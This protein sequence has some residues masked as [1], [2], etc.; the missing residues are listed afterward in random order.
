MKERSMKIFIRSLLFFLIPVILLAQA[1]NIE[2]NLIL[3][4]S[5]ANIFYIGNI[6]PTG[7]GNVPDYFTLEIKNLES[8]DARIKL[9]FEIWTDNTRI[10]YALS[11]AVTLR[12]LEDHIFTSSQLNT[13]SAV[14]NS[15]DRLEV[16]N[17]DVDFTAVERIENPTFSTG[18]LPNGIYRFIFNVYSENDPNT[19]IA[20]DEEI[21]TITNPTTIEPLY[22]GERVNQNV[23]V[24]IPTTFPYFYWQ[25]DAQ[26]FNL[27]VYKKYEDQ[28]IQDVLSRDP[29]LHLENY[30][31]QLF[32]YPAESEPLFFYDETD[33]EI[34]RSIGPVRMLEPGNIYYWFVE[35]VIQTS[36]GQTNLPSDIYQFKVANIEGAQ[37]DLDLILV[38]LRQILGDQYDRYMSGLQEYDPDGNILLNRIPVQVEALVDLVNK[39]RT[40]EAEIKNVVVE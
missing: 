4:N 25:S 8:V 38:Y 17:Y 16:T 1:P 3:F 32:Q 12:G 14:L 24:E 6:D 28:S 37:G 26:M 10:V 21:L 35:A 31:N 5:Q 22:P 33:R 20:S 36:S 39:L 13:G 23:M 40:K 18:K 27:Y 15:G 9:G 30:P 34:G 11:D 19:V 7:L 2:V 29:I